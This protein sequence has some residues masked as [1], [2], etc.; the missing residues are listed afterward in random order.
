ME[1]NLAQN[2]TLGDFI[3]QN[4]E[5]KNLDNSYILVSNLKLRK[6]SEIT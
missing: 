3:Q 2:D 4:K 1:E 6:N 5:L